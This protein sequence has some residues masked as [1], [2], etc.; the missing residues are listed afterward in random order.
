LQRTFRDFDHRVK[1]KDMC[2]QCPVNEICGGYCPAANVS[3]TGSI[4]TP[5]DDYCRCSQLNYDAAAHLYDRVKQS[6]PAFSRMMELARAA[7]S[8]GQ[9]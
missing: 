7:T 6:P 3:S 9:R 1:H 8:D 2:N 5:H 4:Y